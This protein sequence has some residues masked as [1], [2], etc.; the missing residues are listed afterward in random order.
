MTIVESYTAVARQAL[1]TAEK[2]V[3]TWRRGA[4]TITDQA[5]LVA[6]FPTVDPTQP[7]A[8]YFEYV[9][10]TVDLSRD[11]ATRWA[12]LMMSL[13]GTVREQA[14]NGIHLVK[15]QI[16]TVADLATEQTEKAEQ[17]AREQAERINQTQ[18]EH[19][20]QATQAELAELKQAREQA[21]EPYQDLTKAELG[22]LLAERGLPKTGTVEE[23]IELLV[24]VDSQ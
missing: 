19:A 7:V 23:L 12:E 2:S 16:D 3:E 1:T 5:D 8:R 4:Q 22:D 24:S 9:Q 15:D 17:A 14:E 6:H 13:S 11:L 18:N 21:R 10:K 20:R